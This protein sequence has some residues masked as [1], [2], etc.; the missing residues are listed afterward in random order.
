M[1]PL[2]I[3]NRLCRR[4][5]LTSWLSFSIAQI[6][7]SRYGH[8]T[9]VRHRPSTSDARRT[10]AF[11]IELCSVRQT[12]LL[13]ICYVCANRLQKSSDEPAPAV[14]SSRSVLN[15]WTRPADPLSVTS[16]VPSRST[17]SLPSSSLSEKPDDCVKVSCRR[18]Q[19]TRPHR[20]SHI[21]SPDVASLYCYC[22]SVSRCND[23]TLFP[24]ALANCLGF[25]RPSLPSPSDVTRCANDRQERCLACHDEPG[26]SVL[27]TVR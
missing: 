9:F 21:T 27:T 22:V 16:R 12:A 13:I 20:P 1:Q 6:G 7:I 8:P 4:L 14:V 18:C 25:A 17:T 26:Q 10:A 23:E 15:S 11:R 24:L 3:N 19:Q 2:C 5:F